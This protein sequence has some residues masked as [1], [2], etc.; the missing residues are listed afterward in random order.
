MDR[1]EKGGRTLQEPVMSQQDCCTDRSDS[2]PGRKDR[3]AM[4]AS[5]ISRDEAA[6]IEAIAHL[7][8][9]AEQRWKH[10]Q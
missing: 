4:L 5:S 6:L 10:Q 7:M 9:K 8:E 3:A 1:A 2:T